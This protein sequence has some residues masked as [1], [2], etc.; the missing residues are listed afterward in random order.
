MIY[1][2]EYLEEVV[3]CILEEHSIV[4]TAEITDNREGTIRKYINGLNDPNS[5]IY[6]PECYKKVQLMLNKIK[7]KKEKLKLQEIKDRAN[8][9]FLGILYE[10]CSVAQ[11]A[12]KAGVIEETARKYIKYL[13]NPTSFLYNPELYEKVQL[14]L[15]P[16]LTE[17]EI[18]LQKQK[19]KEY[20]DKIINCI[21]NGKAKGETQIET[22][23]SYNK[24]NGYVELLNDPTSDFYN[25]ELYKTLQIKWE[26]NTVNKMR[27]NGR[28]NKVYLVDINNRNCS[29]LLKYL[30]EVKKKEETVEEASLKKYPQQVQLELLLMA[31]TYR[32][33][34]KTIAKWFHT[35]IADVIETF[36]KFN[37]LFDSVVGLFE[38]TV[39]EDE[40][41]EKKAFAHAKEYWNN[42]NTLIKKLNAAKKSNDK[43][44]IAEIK[45][46]IKELHALIDDTR[47]D[48]I[49]TKQFVNLTSEE[50]G[51]IARYRIK[52]NLSHHE[53]EKRLSFSR[54]NIK[55]CEEELAL[56]DP[57]YDEKFDILNRHHK[58]AYYMIYKHIEGN[59]SEED[60]PHF[61]RGGGY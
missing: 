59:N 17:E 51:I 13:K 18:K 39:N 52:Y 23:L 61:G 38:E 2:K 12:E 10:N 34:F 7:N 55:K 1:N 60:V 29:P 47:L 46:K 22:A 40:I 41:N 4:E 30:E 25:P 57:V 31:L 48:E 54:E 3:T 50:R 9:V 53:V 35:S 8:T 14:K 56:K 27:Q 6:N 58:E 21:L 26:E 20:I 28:E 44:A 33:S 36:I 32:V 45:S 15:H 49:S 16:P 5:N 43:E 42:R 11:A 24:M 37:S 19:D